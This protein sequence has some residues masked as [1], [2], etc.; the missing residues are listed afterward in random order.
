MLDCTNAVVLTSGYFFVVDALL[1]MPGDSVDED[2]NKSIIIG[3]EDDSDDG[4]SL[5]AL[6]MLFELMVFIAF[7]DRVGPDLANAKILF[8]NICSMSFS[9]FDVVLTLLFCNNE[10]R[11]VKS[12]NVVPKTF[13]LVFICNPFSML[14]ADIVAVGDDGTVFECSVISDKVLTFK[15]EVVVASRGIVDVLLVVWPIVVVVGVVVVEVVVVV[16]AAVVVVDVVIAAVV[17]V[18]V[19]VVA[20][21]VGIGVV[22]IIG[23]VVVIGMVVIIGVVVVIKLIDTVVG[24]FS[25]FVEVTPLITGVKTSTKGFIGRAIIGTLFS[26]VSFN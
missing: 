14:S 9:V 1:L 7:G 6:R 24:L 21:V 20:A 22:M 8:A 26:A 12:S 5:I 3:S 17:V 13:S 16:V 19:V 10:F 4:K 18:V 15:E 23:V 11:K 2:G 25:G